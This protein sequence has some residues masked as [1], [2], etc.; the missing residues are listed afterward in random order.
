[1]RANGER[2]RRNTIQYF[3]GVV[4]DILGSKITNIKHKNVDNVA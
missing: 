1:M 3:G 4:G 2:A